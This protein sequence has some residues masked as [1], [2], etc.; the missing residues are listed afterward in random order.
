MNPN[1][2]KKPN[3]SED[4]AR[5][6]VLRLYGFRITSIKQMVSFDDQNYH[7]KVSSSLILLFIYLFIYHLLPC[8]FPLIP[9]SI[10]GK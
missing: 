10:L 3:V 7:I 5:D 9:E 2:L 4:L 8:Y 1:D 6:L